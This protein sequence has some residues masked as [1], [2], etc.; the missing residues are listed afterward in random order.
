MTV[1]VPVV[2]NVA[3][4]VGVDVAVEVFV[5]VGVDV[6]VEATDPVAL[7]VAEVVA[8]VVCEVDSSQVYAKLTSSSAVVFCLNTHPL[9][10]ESHPQFPVQSRTQTT[11][12]Q[13]RAAPN[14]PVVPV[15]VPVDVTV[16]VADELAVDVWL[17]V[18]VEVADE[19]ADVVTVVLAVVDADVDALDDAV[20]L[21]DVVT[22]LE[23]D[24][25]AVDVAVDVAVVVQRSQVFVQ[26][27]C[28]A[29]MHM[30]DHRPFPSVDIDCRFLQ[31]GVPF[32]SS[33]LVAELAVGRSTTAPNVA[34]SPLP[35][36]FAR[37]MLV[38][39]SNTRS[40]FAQFTLN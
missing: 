24:E 10:R 1:D 2:V 17:V 23:A 30:A 16:E 7:V 38:F 6:A 19:D 25:V 27:V 11:L 26:S 8:V 35:L 39:R 9:T 36:L 22:E 29:I 13:R 4:A 33:Q 37:T 12:A 28:N 5:E 34:N 21:A 14:L 31:Y 20:V 15:V 3:S 18:A 40:C 32:L